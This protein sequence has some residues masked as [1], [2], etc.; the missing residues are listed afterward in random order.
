MGA[1]TSIDGDVIYGVG[2]GRACLRDPSARWLCTPVPA[3]RCSTGYS[4]SNQA[5]RM[6]LT[7]TRR[8]LLGQA[9]AHHRN[10]RARGACRRDVQSSPP[11]SLL[12]R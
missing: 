8:P 6:D 5:R 3:V 1:P 10:H 4:N 2:C 9:Q 12:Q 11:G 7:V